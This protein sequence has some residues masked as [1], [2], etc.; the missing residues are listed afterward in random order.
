MS[1]ITFIE[2]RIFSSFFQYCAHYLRGAGVLLSAFIVKPLTHHP[3]RPGIDLALFCPDANDSCRA[4]W[5]RGRQRRGLCHADVLFRLRRDAIFIPYLGRLT[6]T[7]RFLT[8]AMAPL[9]ALAWPASRQA[10]SC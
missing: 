2:Q 1:P 9:G 10:V 4:I 6:S 7:M 8:V 3:D 5:Q